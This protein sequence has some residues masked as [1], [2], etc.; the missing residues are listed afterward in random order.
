MPLLRTLAA[1]EC[2]GVRLDMKAVLRRREVL[3]EE[4][5]KLKRAVIVQTGKDFNLD[6]P[7]ETA[8]ALR[9]SSSLSEQT[10]RRLTPAQLEYLASTHGLARLIVKYSRT[11]KLGR[12]LEAICEAVK[13]GK[14]FPIFSQ[15][16]WAHGGL[17]STD[18]RVCEPSGALAASTVIDRT[19]RQRMDDPERSLEILQRVTGDEVLKKDR[20]GRLKHFSPIGNDAAVGD[21]DQRWARMRR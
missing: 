12:Q 18:P 11:R 20:L 14:A 13:D 17:S 6:S 3:A 16:K 5:E 21:L 10:G 2:N 7:T 9:G 19:V 15:V 4:A 8:S 1:K